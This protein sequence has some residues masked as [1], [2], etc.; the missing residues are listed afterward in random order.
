MKWELAHELKAH[1][2]HSCNPEKEDVMPSFEHSV[3]IEVPQ[4]QG[5]TRPTKG[6]EG[7]ETGREPRI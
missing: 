7:E 5:V 2:Y 3:W 6:A 1:H 4:I